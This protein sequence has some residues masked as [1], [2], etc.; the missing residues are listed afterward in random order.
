[1]RPWSSSRRAGGEKDASISRNAGLGRVPGSLIVIRAYRGLGSVP[2]CRGQQTGRIENKG[3]LGGDMNE[4]CQ[5]RIEK[6][7]GGETDT[8]QIDRNRAGEVLPN[9]PAR[10][11]R[12]RQ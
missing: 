7:D 9:D 12:D 11:T 6:S 5:R 4:S 8:D 1:M 3:H 2:Y 10:P